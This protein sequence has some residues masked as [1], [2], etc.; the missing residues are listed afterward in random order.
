M[1]RASV[2][3]EMKGESN[4]R[5]YPIENF[6]SALA[7]V[8][9]RI[10]SAFA[11]KVQACNKDIPYGLGEIGVIGVLGNVGDEAAEGL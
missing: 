4:V 11:V 2:T 5:S 8:C 1:S 9:L 10:F 6:F 3:L 7:I